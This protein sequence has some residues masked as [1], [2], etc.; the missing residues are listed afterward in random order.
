MDT[1]Q[2]DS[3]ETFFDILENWREERYVWMKDFLVKFENTNSEL[4]CPLLSKFNELD[5]IYDEIIEQLEKF[6]DAER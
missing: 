1:K 4:L 3:I 2:S 5:Q 6:E